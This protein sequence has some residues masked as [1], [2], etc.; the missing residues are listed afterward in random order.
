MRRSRSLS[1][2][3][4]NAGVLVGLLGATLSLHAAPEIYPPLR[5]GIEPAV[6]TLNVDAP[7]LQRGAGSYRRNCSAC[8]GADGAG[9]GALWSELTAKPNDLREPAVMGRLSDMD[10]ARVIQYGGFE[11]PPLPGIQR[12]ELVALVAYVRSLSYP[13]LQE[14]ELHPLTGRTVDGFVPVSAAKLGDP[15]P[16]DWLMYRRTWNAWGFSPLDQVSR[17]NVSR[18]TLAWSRAMEP[19]EQETT[20]LVYDGTMFLAHP[21]DVIQALDARTGDLIWEYRGEPVTAG[22]TR[23]R[24]IAIYQDRIFHFTKNEPHLIALDARD[25]SLLWKVP[26]DGDFSSGPVIMG[27]KVVGGRSCSPSDGPAA[28]YI[29]AY[30]PDTGAEIWRRNTIV[31]PEE[32][33]GDSWGDLAWEDRR[34]V[35]AWGSGSYDPALGLIYWGTSVPAPS[36]ERVRGTPGGDVLY[37]NST[38]AL[39]EKT[40]E[41]AWYYQHLPRDNWDMDHVFERLLVDTRVRPDPSAVQWINPALDRGEAH[42]VVTGIPGKTG[43]VYTL[44]RETGEFLWA[45]PTLNQNLVTQIDTATGEVHIDES[46]VVDAFEEILVCPGRAGGKNWPAG[47]YNPNTGLMYQPQQNLCMLHTGNAASPT[48]EEVYAS[49]VVFVEDPTIDQTPYPVGRVDAVSIESGRVAWTHQ[50]RAGM[51]SGLVA[52]AGGLVFGGDANR[53]FKAFDDLSGQV[54]WETILSG[55]VTGHPISYQADG[56]QYIAVPVGGGTAEPERRVLSIHPEMKPS[57]GINAIF[58]FALPSDGVAPGNQAGESRE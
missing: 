42:K 3:A 18:L 40:G 10:L 36:L 52:T 26:V 49:S 31:R 2:T 33:G 19:G 57:R 27:G 5:E 8:H 20:P 29:A 41:I 16:G 39:D 37:S 35:G 32:P 53:R 58:V 45:T 13:D 50:Q 47:A 30:D 43:I 24:N 55:P 56:R 25:G 6:A 46:L 44:N 22:K 15:D 11:M 14:V 21:G 12:E 54:L 9:G 1:R 17:E 34:H 48:P 38:L 23:M 28:C 7:M 4:I 51:L